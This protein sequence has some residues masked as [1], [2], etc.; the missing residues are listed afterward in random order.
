M[1]GLEDNQESLRNLDFGEVV[2]GEIGQAPILYSIAGGL[3]WADG[4]Y[5][6]PLDPHLLRL[7]EEI[8]P[9]FSPSTTQ[10]SS[11]NQMQIGGVHIIPYR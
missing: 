7:E 3:A 6:K 10:Q 8:T 11:T 4:L 9:F 2:D 1:C 5:K